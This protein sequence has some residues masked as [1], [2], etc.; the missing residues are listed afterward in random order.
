MRVI[1]YI[2]KPLEGYYSFERVFAQVRLELPEELEVRVVHACCHSRGVVRR[3]LNCVQA[4]L[5]RADVVHVTGDIHYVVPAVIGRRTVLTVHDLAPLRPKRGWARRVFKKLWYDWPVACADVVTAVSGAIAVELKAEVGDRHADRIVV[6]PNGVDPDFKR[7]ERAWPEE[8]VVLMVGTKP[9][10]NLERMFAALQGRAVSVSVVGCLSM[11][12]K[13]VV[14][15]SGLKVEEKG[16]LD[17][18]GLVRAFVEADLLA[19]ASTYEGFGLPVVEAQTVGRPVLTSDVPALREVAGEGGA[20]LVD[21]LDVDSIRGGFD[22]ILSDAGYRQQLVGKGFE[23]ADRYQV[24]AVA[25]TYAAIY[26]RS[27]GRHGDDYCG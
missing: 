24:S 11:E 2:R 25:T 6:V 20:C 23:N 9:Q 15:R 12:Q 1:H 22:R 27:S 13:E 5:L 18:A 7:V 10:K 19:F 21:P 14:L 4:L 3:F 17:Q 8:P 26:K 16:L